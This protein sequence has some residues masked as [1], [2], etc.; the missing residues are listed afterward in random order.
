MTQ[1]AEMSTSDA[2]KTKPLDQTEFLTF[3]AGGQDYAVDIGLIQ[4]IRGWMEPAPLPDTPKH[5]L[6]AIN[7]RGEVLPLLDL[8][9]RLGLAA[10]EVNE[11]SVII[12]VENDGTPFGLLVDG[13]SDIIAPT[14]DQMQSPPET[15]S[16]GDP[17]SVQ[18]LIL[19]DDRMVRILDLQFCSVTRQP[20]SDAAMEAVDAAE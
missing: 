8:A 9:V 18:A 11:R 1:T 16:G 5:V 14:E 10:P 15:G 7:L 4:E 19:L 20:S 3:Q 12:V 6:G 2:P 17:T 13:V